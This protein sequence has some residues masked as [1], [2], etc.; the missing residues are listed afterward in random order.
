MV[1]ALH[2]SEASF[3]KAVIDLARLNGWIV[4]HFRPAQNSRGEWRTPVAADGKGFPDLVL[5][6]ERVLFRELKTD[7]GRLSQEQWS[8]IAQLGDAGADAGVWM[9]RDWDRIVEELS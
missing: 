3:Q 1:T 2:E 5:V 8:W 7:R 4:A 9:P 6:R